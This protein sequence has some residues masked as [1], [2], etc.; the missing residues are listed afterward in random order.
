[1]RP[2]WLA[3]ATS[4]GR[5]PTPASD[6]RVP[7]AGSEPSSL[8]SAGPSRSVP[9]SRRICASASR[10]GVLDVREGRARRVGVAVEDPAGGACLDAHRGD[11]VGDHVVQLAGD[12]QPLVDDGLLAQAARLGSDGRRLLLQP[13]A[14][15]GRAPRHPATDDRPAEVDDVDQQRHRHCGRDRREEPDPIRLVHLVDH[16]L[17]RR[18]DGELPGDP[19]E[20]EEHDRAD[21]DHHRAPV[22]G[23]R[24]PRQQGDEVDDLERHLPHDLRHRH[25]RDEHVQRGE[26]RDDQRPAATA[27]EERRARR[28]GEPLRPDRDVGVLEPAGAAHQLEREQADGLD[29][30]GQDDV[31][32]P[33]PRP[34]PLPLVVHAEPRQGALARA[35]HGASVGG[36]RCARIRREAEMRTTNRPQVAV[37]RRRPRVRA[38]PWLSGSGAS[39]GP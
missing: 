13:Q 5:S 16:V 28:H 32:A 15:P 3:W 19:R 37:P 36:G 14:L 33:D 24:D 27:Q 7:L 35:G 25:A 20:H 11:T 1:M 18:P 29:A 26:A 9:R 22:A 34:G 6:V 31:L 23:V 4:S 2:S 38:R 39:V 17:R 21:H 30:G 8:P 10:R 12:A